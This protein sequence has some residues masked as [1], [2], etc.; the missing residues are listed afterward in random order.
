MNYPS[1]VNCKY[2]KSKLAHRNSK[3]FVAALVAVGYFTVAGSPASAQWVDQVQNYAATRLPT[4]NPTTPQD[5]AYNLA[6]GV[7]A[8]IGRSFSVVP[9]GAAAYMIGNQIGQYMMR[10]QP[11]P[12]PMAPYNWSAYPFGR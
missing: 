4:V 12:A 10:P 8:L 7:N 6:F 11:V 2:R 5:Y 1:A 3:A 9:G